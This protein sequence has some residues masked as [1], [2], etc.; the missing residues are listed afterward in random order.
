MLRRPSAESCRLGLGG[1]L[2][3]SDRWL[4]LAREPQ[5]C[6]DGAEAERRGGKQD[7]SNTERGPE[8]DGV[9]P[10]RP[11]GGEGGKH[12]QHADNEADDA[13]QRAEIGSHDVFLRRR[14]LV[15]TYIRIF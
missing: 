3:T 15:D 13:I 6:V 12:K 7:R 1:L 10:E 8:H 14:L 9:L 11:A 2:V 4:A 5:R